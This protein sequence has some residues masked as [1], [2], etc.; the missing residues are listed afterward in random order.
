MIRFGFTSNDPA[1]INGA[2]LP[3]YACPDLTNKPGFWAKA[4]PERY[5]EQATILSFYVTRS[6]DVMYAINDQEKGIF[7]SGVNTAGPLWGII[8]IYGN[9]TCMEFVG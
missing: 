5:S 4:L 1:T 2:E 3:R 9:T 8:D 7:F 6:G